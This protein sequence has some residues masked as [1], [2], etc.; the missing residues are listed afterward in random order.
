MIL[1]LSTNNHPPYNV[2]NDYEKKSLV[3]TDE[4]KNHLTGDFD[5]AKQRFYSYQYAVNSVGNFLTKFKKT[6][7]AKNTIVVVTA[8]NNTID[9]IME[10]DDNQ[11]FNSKNIPLYF[12]LPNTLKEKLN[13][14]INVAGSHKD[15][16][17]TLYN[18]TLDNIDYLAIGS[19]LFD[20]TQ[21]KYGFNG[22]MIIN[23][24]NSVKKLNHLED[25]IEDIDLNY[26]KASL[27][28]TQ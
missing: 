13:I 27:A 1:A 11:L 12:Y 23:H 7:F 9:G 6:Q 21:R 8:D 19:N 10:Y 4:I 28:I 3:F 22:S 5:L 16:F 24:N 20:N 17:P 25:K 26:Y 18:L 14:D 2:P 15:I